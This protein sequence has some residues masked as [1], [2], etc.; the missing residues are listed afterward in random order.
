MMEKTKEQSEAGNSESGENE[1]SEE[2]R[3]FENAMRSILHQD[4]KEAERIRKSPVPKDPDAKR[5][6]K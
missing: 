1:T 4:P 5:K 3:N 2:Y 6:G